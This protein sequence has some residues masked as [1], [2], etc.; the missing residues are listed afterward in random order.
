MIPL[1]IT[2]KAALQNSSICTKKKSSFRILF[3]EPMYGCRIPTKSRSR[4]LPL[5]KPRSH[6]LKRRS[7]CH[8]I[9]FD[10]VSHAMTAK[11]PAKKVLH[12]QSFCF[13]SFLV[14][15]FVVI[16]LSLL[17]VLR[18]KQFLIWDDFAWKPTIWWKRATKAT[19]AGTHSKALN[20]LGDF[21]DN[22]MVFPFHLEHHSSKLSLFFLEKLAVP[23]GYM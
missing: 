3:I 20:L 10:D 19:S 13:A 21:C 2:W 6:R 15:V 5:M 11:K 17:V 8:K 4:R 12:F 18:R 9:K 16:A 14:P 23:R 1:V 22:R 7:H